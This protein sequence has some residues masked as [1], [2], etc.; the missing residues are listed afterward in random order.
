[1]E[2]ILK[3][4]THTV[5]RSQCHCSC[6]C[7]EICFIT[8]VIVLLSQQSI[9]TYVYVYSVCVCYVCMHTHTHTHTHTHIHNWSYTQYQVAQNW[10]CSGPLGTQLSHTHGCTLQHLVLIKLLLWFFKNMYPII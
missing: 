1:M 7:E 5:S 4:I 3:K 10:T 8:C 9:Y 2:S 6:Y